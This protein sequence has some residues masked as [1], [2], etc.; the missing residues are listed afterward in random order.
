MNVVFRVDASLGIGTGH[1][2]RCLTLADALRKD[3][4][5]CRFVCRPH[6]GHLIEFIRERGFEVVALAA[7]TSEIWEETGPDHAAWLGTDWRSDALK[8][9]A[10]IGEE[11][12]DWLIVDHYALDARWER[13][14]RGA[15]G[16]IMVIDDLADRPHDCDL[17]LDQ[18]LGCA[19]AHYAAL[20]PQRCEL[21]VGPHN[22]LLRP[23][24]AQLRAA[25][26]LRRRHGE[27]QSI[28]VTMGGVDKDN[29]TGQVLDALAECDLPSDATITVVMGPTAPWLDHVRAAAANM[30]QPIRVLVNVRDMARLMADT[31]LA[32]GAAGTTSWERCCLGVPS[33]VLA[34][35][36]NQR[37]IAE[38]LDAAGVACYA[39]PSNNDTTFDLKAFFASVARLAFDVDRRNMMIESAAALTDGRGASR[40]AASLRSGKD[41]QRTE[42]SFQFAGTIQ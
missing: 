25:S 31:D 18:N 1:V 9:L 24:F 33:L 38:A 13:E 23:E 26:L 30:P 27:L 39:P 37:P 11:K 17:L 32:I 21:L 12:P 15:C 16:K 41:R 28:L 2:M 10:A 19:G 4:A 40:V 8:V 36:D 34:I 22:A 42:A 14:L 3:G 20:V 5:S 35:A 6:P 7:P 29:V